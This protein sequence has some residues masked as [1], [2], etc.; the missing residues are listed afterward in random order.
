[1]LPTLQR[2]VGTGK[3][4]EHKPLTPSE[5]FSFYA[6]EIPGFFYR[7]GIAPPGVPAALVAAN[8]SLRFQIDGRVWPAAGA[9]GNG[10]PGF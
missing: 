1:M 3:A 10:A 7:V 4:I 5:D 9:E 8:H 2:I 6:Q